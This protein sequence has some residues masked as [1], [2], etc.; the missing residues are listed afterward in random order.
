M[1]MN[2]DKGHP[3]VSGNK[4]E[5]MLV[6]IGNE[7]SWENKASHLLLITINS[8]QYKAQETFLSGLCK[9]ENRKI[10]T[11]SGQGKYIRF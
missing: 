6:K 8:D 7:I 10:N 5:L 2:N 9:T 1:K 4:H 11:S 3:L